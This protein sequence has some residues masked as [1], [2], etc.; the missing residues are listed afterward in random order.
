M[1]LGMPTKIAASTA[2]FLR[3]YTS[4]IVGIVLAAL[5]LDLPFTWQNTN[6]EEAE[7]QQHYHPMFT[8]LQRE[9]AKHDSTAIADFITHD[10]QDIGIPVSSVAISDLAGMAELLPHSAADS[11]HVF[12]D[13]HDNAMLYQPIPNTALMLVL[14]PAPL[15]LAEQNLGWG[16]A[17]Y[18]LVAL[19]LLLWLWPVYR[20]LSLLRRAAVDF[21]KA[22]FS[23]RV[24]LSDKSRILP[25]ATAFN[26]MAERLETLISSH[27]ELTHAVSHELRTPLARFKFSMEMLAR[28]LEPERKAQYLNDMKGDVTELETLIDEMLSYAKLSEQNLLMNLVDIDIKQWLQHEVAHYAHETIQ[29]TCGFSAQTPNGDCRV[30]CNPDLMARAVHNIIRNGLRYAA[31]SII[32]H[33]H[34]THEAAFIRICDDGPGIPHDKRDAIFEP[35]SRLE[36]SRDKTSGGYGLGLAI[37]ARIMQRHQ[38]SIRVDNCEPQGACFKLEWPRGRLLAGAYKPP[39]PDT[40]RRN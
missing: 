34:L 35:F 25:V 20:D 26:A 28:N 31:S 12:Y 32:V 4:L 22:D 18:L 24:V 14:G 19:I 29:V 5:L 17:Y 10:L 15:T 2:H 27:K 13:S 40:A 9:I 23:T 36:T 3:S 11:I 6:S 33:A 30:T 21:G 1:E 39:T 38:G 16:I 7:L 37:A 8:L